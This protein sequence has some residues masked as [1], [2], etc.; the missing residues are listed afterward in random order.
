[1]LVRKRPEKKKLHSVKSFS[2]TEDINLREGNWSKLAGLEPVNSG[3]VDGDSLLGTDVRTV[4]QVGVLTLLL[5][6]QIK[7]CASL[8]EKRPWT[9]SVR[10]DE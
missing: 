9:G 5:G 10:T 8:L 3:C 1:V 7:T 6:L 2:N 4:L